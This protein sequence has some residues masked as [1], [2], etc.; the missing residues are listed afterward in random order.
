MADCVLVT[1]TKVKWAQSLDSSLAAAQMNAMGA[2]LHRAPA[3][4]SATN[5]YN[6]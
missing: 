6:Q 3:R 5:L 1:D 2:V 4:G